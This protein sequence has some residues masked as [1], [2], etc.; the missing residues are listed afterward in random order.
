[1]LKGVSGEFGRS[2]RGLGLVPDFVRDPN[3]EHRAFVVLLRGLKVPTA[4]RGS[5]QQSC[6]RA[7]TGLEKCYSPRKGLCATVCDSI[8]RVHVEKPC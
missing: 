1:M 4:K 8:R 3:M 5:Q 7:V 6:D 2:R